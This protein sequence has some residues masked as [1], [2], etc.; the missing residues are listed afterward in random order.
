MIFS[1]NGRGGKKKKD[2]AKDGPLRRLSLPRKSQRKNHPRMCKMGAIG[3]S[4]P[5]VDS[6]RVIERHEPDTARAGRANRNADEVREYLF[7]EADPRHRDAQPQAF[8]QPPK[9]IRTL[10]PLKK[11]REGNVEPSQYLLFGREARSSESFAGFP[12]GLQVERLIAPYR[13]PTARRFDREG[14]LVAGA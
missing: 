4:D 14:P 12:D 6:T 13:R 8:A 3:K 9:S 5:Q 2:R 7:L 11:S 1:T 10:R